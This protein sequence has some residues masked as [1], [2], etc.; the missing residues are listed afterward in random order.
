MVHNSNSNRNEKLFDGMLKTA[1]EESMISE[2]ETLPKREEL[3]EMYPRSEIFD[4]RVMK[5]INSEEKVYKRKRKI[6]T[7]YKFA[8]VFMAL[9]IVASITVYSVE[10]WRIRFMNFII[11]IRQDHTVIDFNEELTGDAFRMDEL[12]LGYVPDGFRLEE[13]AVMGEQL[14]ILFANDDLHFMIIMNDITAS[15]AIDTEDAKVRRLDIN[16]FQAFF[17][18]NDNVNILVWHDN[19]YSYTIT[20]NIDEETII[21]IAKNM[22]R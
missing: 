1:L 13:S 17:S 11:D 21:R 9:I 3:D 5:I 16:E 19:A 18:T 7:I 6:E 15:L 12:Y 10:A 22:E 4:K 14:F 2:M 8:A 20:G